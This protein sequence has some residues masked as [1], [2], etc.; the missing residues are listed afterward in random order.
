MIISHSIS[1]PKIAWIY[2][3][4]KNHNPEE[5]GDPHLRDIFQRRFRV[6]SHVTTTVCIGKSISLRLS[7]KR[8]QSRRAVGNCEPA[9]FIGAHNQPIIPSNI[10]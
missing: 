5:F 7:L 4:E 10:F 8:F 3:V 1:G 9:E 6:W 2:V